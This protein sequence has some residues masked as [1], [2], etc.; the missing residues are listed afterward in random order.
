MKIRILTSCTG[1][2]QHSPENQLTAED[3]QLIHDASAFSERESRLSQ[4]RYP[5]TQL[6]TGQQHVRLMRGVKACMG[7]EVDCEVSVLSAGYGLIPGGREIV[8]YE[9][10]FQGM[11]KK[12]L[13]AWAEHLQIPRDAR[14][15]FGEPADFNLILL[16]ESYLAALGLD[17]DVT[18]AAPTLFFCGKAGVKLIK[19]KG[20]HR[21]VRLS[22]SEAKRF[23]CGLVALKGEVVTQLLA[24]ITGAPASVGEVMNTEV[25]VLDWLDG[26]KKPVAAAPKKKPVTTRANPNVDVV[27]QIPKSWWEKPH[28]EELRYFIP[29]WDDLVDPDYD[30]LNDEHSGGRGNW[31]NE[32]YAH[33]MYPEPSY[34]GI[35]M[36]RAVAEKSKSKKA[37]INEMGVHR[38]LRVPREFPIMGDCGAFDYIMEDEPPY[39]TEDVIDY[40]TRLD[41]DMGVSVDHLIVTATE[42]QKQFRYDLT[43]HNAEEFLNQHRSAGLKWEPIGAVQGWDPKSYAEAARQYVAMGYNRIALGGL[44]RSSTKD[45]LLYL[46]EVHKVVPA[47]VDIHLFGLARLAAIEEFSQLGVTSVDNASP[48]RRAWLGDKDNYWTMSGH[49][50]RAIRIPE[51]GKSFRAKRMISE[52]RATRAFVEKSASQCIQA[53]RAYDAGQTS[54]DSVLDSIDEFDHL[55]TPDRPSLREEYR[56][57][58][59]LKPWRSCPCAICQRDGVEVIIFR[60]NNRNRRRG[61]HNTYVFYRMLQRVLEGGDTSFL[62][63]K[64]KDDPRQ[65]TLGLGA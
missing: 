64:L 53:V 26:G 54:I 58:L 35:L 18:F 16:G 14:Q 9:V 7:S 65:M 17:D 23:S 15:W 47:T 6:Y 8:P 52:G 2:K 10:T 39:S 60:G 57:T 11:R 44:V 12:E 29:E 24:K 62:H 55:I 42:A 28:R 4:S 51:P 56:Q 5:A 45:I 13:R 37:R 50:F 61:F 49:H 31:S 1:E 19:G 34:D 22:N 20:P 40:Y 27:I 43:I 21:V 41:F 33:Q 3:F 63:V 38:F 48:L 59:E 46:Q 32:V 25:D 30:F 36:S